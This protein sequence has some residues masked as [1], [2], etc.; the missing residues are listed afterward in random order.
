[1][2]QS[3]EHYFLQWVAACEAKI[4]IKLKVKLCLCFINHN[5]M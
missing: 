5:A 4:G 1:M 3:P 2:T